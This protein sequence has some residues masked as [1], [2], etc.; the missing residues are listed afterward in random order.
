MPPDP[1]PG[2]AWPEPPEVVAALRAVCLALPEA[3]EEQAW[4]GTRWRIRT[5]TFAHVLMIAAGWPPVYARAA[6]DDGPLC[7][8]MFRS[9]GAELELLRRHGRPYFAPPWR[10]DEVGVAIDESTDWDEIAELVRESY[11][12]QAPRKL[13]GP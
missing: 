5:R 12:I 8:L 2:D 9:R 7:V 10:A 1:P 6:G 4:V 11:R 3:H 13:K